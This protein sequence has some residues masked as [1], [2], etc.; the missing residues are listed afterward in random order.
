MSRKNPSVVILLFLSMAC[1]VWLGTVMSERLAAE[2]TA[3]GDPHL[4]SSIMPRLQQVSPDDDAEFTITIIN[5]GPVA[6]NKVT[7]NSPTTPDCNRNDLGP[8]APGE[9]EAYD[10]ERDDVSQSYLNVIQVKGSAEGFPDVTHQTDA[11]VRVPND[12]EIRILKEPASQLV[13]AGGEATF[14]VRITNFSLSL[15]KVNKIDDN[16]VDDCDAQPD[17]L[18]LLPGQFLVFPCEMPDVQEPM[19]T[20]IRFEAEDLVT[21]DEFVATDA[22]WVEVLKLDAALTA[23]TTSLP[24]PGDLITYTVD[25]VNSGSVWLTPTQLTTD[26]FGDLLNPANEL[27]PAETNTCLAPSPLPSIA[28]YGGAYR[29][30]FVAEVN[31]Q[32]PAFTVTLTATGKESGGLST[33][34]TAESTITIENVAAAMNLALGAEPPFITPPGRMVVFSIHIENTSAVDAITISELEDEFLGDLDGVGNCELPVENLLPGDSYTCQFSEQVTGEDGDQHSRQITARAFSDDTVPEDLLESATVTVGITAQLGGELYLP[35]A[36]DD[37][38][39][40]ND[41]CLL[42][43]PLTLGRQYYFLPPQQYD[44]TLPVEQRDQDYFTFT[45]EEEARVQIVLTSFLP[46]FVPSPPQTNKGQLIVRG[47]SPNQ[48]PPCAPSV[49]QHIITQTN[50]QF[51]V[52]GG[53]VQEAGRYYIQ[54][55]NDGPSNVRTYYGLL[56]R[57]ELP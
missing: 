17:N 53:N 19:T 20:I 31:S 49:S 22:A 47:H 35:I 51:Q 32:P 14:Q 42:A 38:V 16:L 25:L 27:V 36:A 55:I 30:T 3:A 46:Q 5:T 56:V 43:Y 34:T 33:T 6:F 4:I 41:H 40:P 12:P 45:L 48:N 50:H 8:L 23:S 24:E 15:L 2:S 1:A 9:S 10:C 26:R 21:E 54:I 37:T 13:V 29:C 7:V 39:E 57:A 44:D 11:Y 18:L 28:P 52:A